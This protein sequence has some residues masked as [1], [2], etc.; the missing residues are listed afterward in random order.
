MNKG[1]CRGFA[2]RAAL[3]SEEQGVLHTS[4]YMWIVSMCQGW[5]CSAVQGNQDA[6]KHVI[7]F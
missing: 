2:F 4:D 6:A 1:G 5:Q 7:M 3:A